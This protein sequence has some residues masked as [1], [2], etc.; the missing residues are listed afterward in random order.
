MT[1]TGSRPEN[2]SSDKR[3]RRTGR[4]HADQYIADTMVP[5]LDLADAFPTMV[6]LLGEH[7]TARFGHPDPAGLRI[8]DADI[9]IM[10]GNLVS[11]ISGMEDMLWSDRPGAMTGVVRM[12][13]EYAEGTWGWPS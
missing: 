6:E 2:S 13:R 8:S 4:D 5:L 12:R 9:K 1:Q 11:F 3:E 7:L 10:W